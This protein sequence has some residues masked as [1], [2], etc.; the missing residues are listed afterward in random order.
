MH[1]KGLLT[2]ALNSIGNLVYID[3]V[4]TG[5]L[6]NCYCPSCKEK[7]VVKNGGMKRVHHFAHASGTYSGAYPFTF[8][9]LIRV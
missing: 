2:Y 4:D 6:C 1:Q 3:E 9:Q 5:Q 8:R 7:L